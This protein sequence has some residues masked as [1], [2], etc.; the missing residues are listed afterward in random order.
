CRI[1]NHEPL[2]KTGKLIQEITYGSSG[3]SYYM[4]A[5][6]VDSKGNV[7]LVF[8]RS[9][10]SQYAGLFFAGRRSTDPMGTLSNSIELQPGLANYKHLYQGHNLAHWGDYNGIALDPDDS[11]WIY[12][13][14]AQT[15][16]KYGTRVGRI[17]Y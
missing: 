13:E 7:V 1:P 2:D 9:G 17:T 16:Q 12:G 6:M 8:N 3:L 11:I 15:A 4:P 14:F 10:K 5:V